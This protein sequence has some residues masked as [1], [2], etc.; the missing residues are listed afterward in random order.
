MGD[1]K[2][3]HTE[4]EGKRE[5]NENDSLPDGSNVEVRGKEEEEERDSTR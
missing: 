1:W 4:R 5:W 3:W 2:Y